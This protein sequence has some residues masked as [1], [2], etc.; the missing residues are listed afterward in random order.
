[1]ALFIVRMEHPDGPRWNEFM[2]EHITYLKTLI[3]E[4]HLLASGP[5]KRT[6][7]RAGF[8]IIHANTRVDVQ[9]LIDGD[10]FAR[11]NIISALTI[12]EWDPL[13]GLLAD[14]SSGQLPSDLANVR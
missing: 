7:L 12:E 8:L 10:P 5:L 9:G 11:E 14:H 2:L 6:P 13:F 1:M 3:D 4:G